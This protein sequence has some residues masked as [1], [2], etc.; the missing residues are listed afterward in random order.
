MKMGKWENGKNGKNGKNVSW[1]IITQVAYLIGSLVHSLVR[2][3]DEE[4]P[5]FVRRLKLL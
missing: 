4:H 3:L 1:F 2:A 5:V